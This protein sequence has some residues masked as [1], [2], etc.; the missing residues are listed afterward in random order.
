MW[1]EYDDR[2]LVFGTISIPQQEGSSLHVVVFSS[3]LFFGFVIDWC[4]DLPLYGFSVENEAKRVG[5]CA[6]MEDEWFAPWGGED[7]LLL[8]FF[9]LPS[10]F[11]VLCSYGV[12]NA[13]NWS[14]LSKKQSRRWKKKANSIGYVGM[15]WECPRMAS[16]LGKTL[17]VCT[18]LLRS[19]LWFHDRYLCSRTSGHPFLFP[20]LFLLDQA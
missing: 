9:Y 1:M 10:S 7:H 11:V 2:L 19:A 5:Q 3:L 8:W 18:I 4:D 13:L 17:F 20:I 14:P 15:M 12:V 6:G 16:F